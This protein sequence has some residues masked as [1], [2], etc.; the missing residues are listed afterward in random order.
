MPYYTPQLIVQTLE[1]LNQ[2][3]VSDT[4]QVRA[5][6]LPPASESNLVVLQR[7]AYPHN[8]KR[9][10]WLKEPLKERDSNKR[11]SLECD[12]EQKHR[13]TVTYKKVTCNVYHQN[14]EYKKTK[15]V[16]KGIVVASYEARTPIP[17]V[18][19]RK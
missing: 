6:Y 15:V 7:Q 4:N 18:L 11:V 1:T 8:E 3:Q 5:A 10:L 14:D 12:E 9:G 16:E 2:H 17:L 13:N 19:Q